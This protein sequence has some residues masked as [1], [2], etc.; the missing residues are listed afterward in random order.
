MKLIIDIPDNIYDAIKKVQR[1]ISGQRSGK[2]LL[3]ILVNS[4]EN[5]IPLDDVKAEINK[6]IINEYTGQNEYEIALS[7]GLELALQIIDKHIGK[8]ESEDKD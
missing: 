7:D 8:A 1:I 2:T 6:N 3:Q 5:G 4:V